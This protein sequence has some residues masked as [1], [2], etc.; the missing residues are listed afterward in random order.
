MPFSD[1]LKNSAEY[2]EIIKSI[3]NGI[4]PLNVVCGASAQ[5]AHLIY[6]LFCEK[7]ENILVICPSEFEAKTLSLDLKFFAEGDVL[8]FPSKD[9]VFY[10]VDTVSRSGSAER[11]SVCAALALN[12][13]K[14]I[15]VAGIEAVMQFCAEYERFKNSVLKFTIGKEFDIDNLLENLAQMGYVREDMVEG[16]GQFSLRGG[17]L[18]VFSPNY[19]EPVRVEFFDNETDSIRFFDIEKQTTIEKI[20]EASICACREIIYSKDDKERILSDLRNELIKLKRKKSDISAA[21]ENLNA[22]IEKFKEKYYFASIDKYVHLIYSKIPSV[23]DYFNKNSLIFIDDEKRCEENAKDFEQNF[24][25]GVTDLLERGVLY[26]S[27]KVFLKERRAMFS[28]LG[29]SLLIGLSAV[30]YSGAQIKFK[31]SI[32]M[33]V[34]SMNSFHGKIEFLYD[35]LRDWKQKKST[36]VLLAGGSARCENLTTALNNADIECVFAKEFNQNCLGR[37]NVMCKS[38]SGG[39]YYPDENFVLISDREIF[40]E[41]KRKRKYKTDD[42][43]KIHSFTDISPGDY[44]VHQ[45]HGIGKYEGIQ[46]LTTLGVTK[47]YLK[48]SYHGTDKL[49]VPVSQIDMLY[50]YIGSTQRKVSVNRLGGADWNKAK[51][52]VKASTADLAKYLIDLYAA[53]EKTK[54]FAFSKD[55]VW[56][57]Q[58][59]DTFAYN[60]TEDQLKCI[61][62]VKRDMESEKPMDRLLCGDVGYGKTEVAMRAAFKA[63]MDSKQVAYLVPTTVLAMQHYNNFSNR[64]SDFPI[65]VEM[66][67]RFKTPHQQKEILKKLKTGEVDII[68]GTHRI[69]QKDLVFKDLGLLIIDEEQRFGVGHKEKLKEIRKNVDVL[70]LT[71]TPI[72][73]TLHMAMVNI[74]DMSVITQPPENRYPVQTYVMDYNESV[75]TDAIRKEIGRGGQVYYLYNKVKGI[76]SVAE[77]ISSLISEAKVGVGH[78]QMSE[79]ALEDVMLDMVNG[80]INVLVCTTIIET[81]LDISN[82]NTIIIENA[83]K[84]GLAQL[85]Q[86]RGRVGRSN[87]MAY[88]YLTYRRDKTLSEIATKRLSAIR[89]FTEFGSG[90]KIAMRD[91]QIRGAGNLLGSQQHGHMDAVGYDMYCKILKQSVDEMTNNPV[92]EKLNTVVD[93]NINAHISEKY[94]PNQQQRIDAYKKIAAIENMDD[95]YDVTEELIDRYGDLPDEVV[96]VIEAALIKSEAQN[97]GIV[98]ITQKDENIIFKF[99][100]GKMDMKKVSEAISAY[101]GKLLFSAGEVC[102]LTLK[103]KKEHSKQIISNIKN[104]LQLIK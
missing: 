59:E 24:G 53:R 4:L 34:Q 70:T 96:N 26:P 76:Y 98:E 49:Y 54:G 2:K 30:F 32:T 42:E 97:A 48:I 40:K 20:N 103:Q 21:I 33:N 82:V 74:R 5:K 6:S 101:K 63:V 89:E 73:R 10:D 23:I 39:F 86:L 66:L 47:D 11:L 102:Y 77:R 93:L 104:L 8:F 81:G 43:N 36:V 69:L 100:P 95:Y 84:M 91:L 58:F 75:I 38:L 35:D 22:D 90:F 67:S 61:E 92:E 60:E 31:H 37:I 9:Y 14:Y 50:K 57:R 78:G 27:N 85:Y 19:P 52:R 83:D 12:E 72:P 79:G 45:V 65:R 80:D 28:Y 56:Q 68:I 99:A 13:K 62:E 94:I 18:D 88:A 1:I 51:A 16:V 46:K 44:V 71:A 55:T 15:T 7:K 87:K 25:E 29:A 41:N 64:M 3:D 17:I